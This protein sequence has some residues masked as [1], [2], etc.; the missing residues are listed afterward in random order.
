M[1]YMPVQI[2]QRHYLKD[3]R[4]IQYIP[5]KELV[6]YNFIKANSR[7]PIMTIMG[8][9]EGVPYEAAERPLG[10]PCETLVGAIN[11]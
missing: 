5:M 10:V 3:I 9:L 7:N 8:Y 1:K 2:I 11:L 4:S 6:L